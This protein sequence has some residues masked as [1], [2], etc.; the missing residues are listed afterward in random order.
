[1]LRQSDAVIDR[2]AEVLEPEELYRQPQLQRAKT[3]S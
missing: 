3:L 2:G 1:M